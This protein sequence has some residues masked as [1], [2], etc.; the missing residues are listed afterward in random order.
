M[1]SLFGSFKNLV[2]PI[3]AFGNLG[4]EQVCFNSS[5]R[6]LAESAFWGKVASLFYMSIYPD[7]ETATK[8]PGDGA[9][10]QLLRPQSFKKHAAHGRRGQQKRISSTGGMGVHDPDAGFPN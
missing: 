5:A 9:A 4:K 1:Q 3:I 6:S 8:T 7:K 10:G 2:F